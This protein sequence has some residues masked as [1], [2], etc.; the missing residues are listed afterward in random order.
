MIFLAKSKDPVAL[1]KQ[2]EKR[3]ELRHL[4]I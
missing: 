2:L 1:L 3:G 4:G